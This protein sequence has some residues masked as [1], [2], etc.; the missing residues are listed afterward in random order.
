MAMKMF[1]DRCGEEINPKAPVTYA[2]MRRIKS[3]VNFEDYELCASCAH[4]LKLWLNGKKGENDER[5][6]SRKAHYLSL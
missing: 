4:E 3:G 6:Q 1:C 2:G 5:K